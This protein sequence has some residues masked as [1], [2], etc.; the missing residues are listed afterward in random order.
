MGRGMDD[1]E[2]CCSANHMTYIHASPFGIQH[3]SLQAVS[4]KILCHVHVFAVVLHVYDCSLKP[5]EAHD[6]SC[7]I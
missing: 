2:T 6:L 7:P 1:A 3:E 4:L 5:M